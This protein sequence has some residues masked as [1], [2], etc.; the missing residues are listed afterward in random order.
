MRDIKSCG[1]IRGLA[2]TA[3]VVL[4]GTQAFAQSTFVKNVGQVQLRPGMMNPF[5]LPAGT[6]YSTEHVVVG[7]YANTHFATIQYAANQ[8]GLKIRNSHRYDR[9]VIMEITPQAKNM[10]MTVEKAVARLLDNPAVRFAE[11]DTK[12]TP[13]FIPNDTRF[14]EQWGMHNTGQ[15]GGTPDADIDAPEAWDSI[16]AHPQVV[17][18]VCD[19]GFDYNHE[20]LTNVM[21]SNPGEIPNNNID[22]DAN[23]FIDDTNGWDFS[24]GDRDVQPAPGDTHGTHVAGTVGA[25]MNNGKGVAGVGPNIRLMGLRMYGGA[26]GFMS[27]LTAAV[28]YGWEN[29]ATVISVSYNIDGFT[30]ALADAVGRAKAAD[31]VYC[32][33]AG[34]NGQQNPPR[35]ALRQMHDNVIFVASSTRNDTISGFSN[36]GTLV[37]VAAP[38]SDILSTFPNN[39]YASISGTS[40]ATPHMSGVIAV[41]RSL[42]PGST[43]REALNIILGV[44]DKPVGITG[45]VPGG[46][47]NLA[48]AISGQVTGTSNVNNVVPVIG[49]HTGGNFASFHNAGDSNTY[50]LLSVLVP[51]RG[52]YAAYDMTF[53]AGTNDVDTMRLSLEGTTDGLPTAVYIYFFNQVTNAWELQ[54]STNLGGPNSEFSFKTRKGAND[55]ISTPG[56]GVKV[57]IFTIQAIKRRS[58]TPLPYTL[59]TDMAK[60]E[61]LGG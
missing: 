1:F 57:R 9:F 30:Q 43:A 4:L 45:K 16:M 24:D 17:V 20:D 56:M 58:G 54:T 2:T 13:D 44:T 35:Q 50:D 33:S 48:N 31:V 11:F 14:G 51:N 41:I 22:D 28:D 6:Q 39:A 61:M 25:E 42:N 37:E 34:N 18:G 12:I 53:V 19:D 7:F 46:R 47:V 52:Y 32:N 5:A 27:S 55:F 49:V 8:V 26:G 59:K 10:G 23:G 38:G 36:W 60:L 40:M 3:V 29:G 15:S 21:W